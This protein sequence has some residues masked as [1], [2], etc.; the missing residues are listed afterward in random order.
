MAMDST[1][2]V[3]RG[4]RKVKGSGAAA[5]RRALRD[6]PTVVREERGDGWSERSADGNERREERRGSEE[7]GAT[8]EWEARDVVVVTG[9]GDGADS[10]LNNLRISSS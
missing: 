1:E 2:V 4:V 3:R 8:R 5:V 9:D 7:R 10:A 6:G